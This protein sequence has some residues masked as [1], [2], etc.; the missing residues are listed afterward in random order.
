MRKIILTLLIIHFSLL[1]ANAQWEIVNNQ[2][3]DPVSSFAS[4]GNIL[5][6]AVGGDGIYKTTNTE[7]NWSLLNN[8]IN[9]QQY[10]A[11]AVKDSIM[12]IAS[13]QGLFRTTDYGNTW[14]SLQTI[15]G[16]ALCVIIVDNFVYVGMLNGIHR[17]SNWGN[18]WVNINEGLPFHKTCISLTFY[19]SIIFAGIYD[20][21]YLKIFKSTNYG[22]NWIYISQDIQ[23]NDIPYSLYAC[24]NL[25]LCGTI[26]GV[27]KTT[28]GGIN[29]NL[30]TNIPNSYYGL[31]GFASIGMKNIFITS[32]EY[33]FYVSN[34]SGYTFIQKNEG[35]QSL[36]C[37]ALRKFGNYLFLG[38]SPLMLSYNTYRR[39]ISEVVEVNKTGSEIPESYKLYQNYPNPFNSHTI[40]KFQIKDS[41]FVALKIHDVSGKEITTPVSEKKSAGIYEV[42]FDAGNLSSG[43]YFYSLYLNGKIIDT[44]KLILLK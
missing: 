3:T 34:D 17:S 39:P 29:W 30:I 33:G 16:S 5:Y 36:R 43:I 41:R 38:T 24:E 2:I 40:I 18:D 12:F 4:Y 8:G 1:T 35:L 14:D 11:I 19:N 27:Y 26:T 32:W 28:N 37:T 13:D 9:T 10:N 31:Y 44:K 15:Q 42:N 21:P 20:L 25:L 7:I 22:E 6:A 23:N